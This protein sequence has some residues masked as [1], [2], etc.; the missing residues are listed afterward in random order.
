MKVATGWTVWGSNAGKNKGFF[1]LLK[2]PGQLWG[3]RNL[4]FSGYE[5]A[6][7]GS[8]RQGR[9]VDHFPPSSAEINPLNA[10][11]NPFCYLLALLGAHHFLH[12]S[13]IRVKLLTLRQLMF[14]IYIYIY[15]YGAPILDVSRS[16]TAT[17][18]SR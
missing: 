12:V 14:Y 2:H 18:H 8:K 7:S 3:R 10:E 17:Q 9:D 6:F 11:L 5:E 13:R 4:V 1:C 16:H 15:I